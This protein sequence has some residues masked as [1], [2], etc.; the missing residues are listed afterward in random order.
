MRILSPDQQKAIEK[1]RRLKVGALFMSCG[2][3]KTQAASILINSVTGMDLLIWVCPCRTKGDLKEEIEQCGLRYNP[4]I[5]GVESIGQSS[6]IYLETLELARNAKRCFLVVDES[7][8]IKNMKALRTKR[9]LEISRFAEYKLILNGTPVTRDMRDAYA[10]ITFLSPEILNMSYYQFCENYCCY[11]KVKKHGRTIKFAVTG[12]AN[13]DHFL[14]LAKP[15]IYQCDL[16][17]SLKK[18]YAERYWL[19]TPEEYNAY[20]N[21]KDQFLREAAH[22]DNDFQILGMLQKL[23]HSYCCCEDKMNVLR[24]LVTPKT[25]IYCKFIKS[26]EWVK[27][28]FPGAMVLTYG[29]NSFGLNLQ[30]YNRIV[31]FDK[32]FDYAF[33]EQSEARIYRTGQQDDCE[34]FDLTGDFGLENMID[35]CISKKLSLVDHF[36][37]QGRK[38]LE[39]L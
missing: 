14:S 7:L 26:A 18:K 17:L 36:K 12:Y 9:L 33:R 10:Q 21:L 39:E 16:K 25:I 30:A 31:Y 15:Y 19:P 1:L 13:V 5:I 32:T 2:T 22:L 28:A 11:S 23:Q 6:R 35:R 8:K 37:K 4:V 27:S 24:E 38:A 3:G 34:Y 29:K 20:N